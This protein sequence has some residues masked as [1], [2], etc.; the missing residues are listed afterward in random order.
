LPGAFATGLAAFLLGAAAAAAPPPGRQGGGE[1]KDLAGSARTSLE[2]WLAEQGER[3]GFRVSPLGIGIPG[4]SFFRVSLPPEAGLEELGEAT[5]FH[6]VRG[7]GSVVTGPVEIE[8]ARLFRAVGLGGGASS[9][10]LEALGRA[11]LVLSGRGASVVTG[12]DV[13]GLAL[14]FE[15]LAFAGPSLESSQG[16]AALSFQAQREAGPG[17]EPLT[18]LLVRA[19]LDASGEARLAIEEREVR[20]VPLR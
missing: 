11:V 17:R 16:G 4:W 9:I 10:P 1:V 6:A 15:G 7:D 20:P 13:P 8:L 3:T 18:F 14:R 19:S 5:R 12:A 2:R